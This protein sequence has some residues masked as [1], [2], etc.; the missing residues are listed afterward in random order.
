M[1]R[2]YQAAAVET[3]RG[4]TVTIQLVTPDNGDATILVSL[5]DVDECVMPTAE[6]TIQE[7]AEFRELLRQACESARAGNVIEVIWPPRPR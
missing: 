2:R 6:F 3:S 4:D 1:T 5:D 7:A